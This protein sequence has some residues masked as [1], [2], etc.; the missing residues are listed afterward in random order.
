M[1]IDFLGTQIRDQGSKKASRQE[2]PHQNHIRWPID[3][4]S[5]CLLQ[6][7]TVLKHG[8]EVARCSRGEQ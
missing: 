5:I 4:A 3:Y 1:M 8:V 6:H 2:N 7:E